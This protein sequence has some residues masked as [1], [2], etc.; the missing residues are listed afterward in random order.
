MRWLTAHTWLL[1]LVP[2]IAGILLCY[3]TNFP[4]DL[5]ADT[6]VDYLDCDT[7]LCLHLMDEGQ[8][9][10]RTIRYTAQAAD[11]SRLLLYL[12]KDSL[13]YPR[14][15]DVLLVQTSVKRGELL[16]EFD[17]GRYLRMQGLVGTAWANRRNWQVVAHQP[18]TGIRATAKR[19]Q[20]ALHERY[21]QLGI[22]PQELGI[23]SALTLGYRDELDRQVQEHF[24]RAG[25]MH[26]LAVS[27]LHTGI[28]WGIILW[29]L[30]L[31][32]AVKPMY[33]H[34]GWR[35]AL[36]II[37]IATLWIYAFVTGLSESVMRSALMLTM[38]EI[39][40]LLR[41]NVS[42]VNS[43]AAA[44][45]I[46]LLIN[47]LALWDV[48][49]Q[50]SFMAM[51]GILLVAQRMQQRIVVRGK[52]GQYVCGLLVMSVSAQI[53]TLPISLHYFG[54]TSNYFALTNLVVVPAAF[55]L[56]LLGI[57][58]LAL[59]CFCVGEYIARLAEYATCGLRK[60]VEWIDSLPY[61]ST[62]IELSAAAVACCYGAII[63]ALMMMRREKVNWWW[64]AGVICC[65]AGVIV[66]H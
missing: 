36:G 8:D 29:I 59:S 27:G 18:I 49:F 45:V 56:L 12:Q 53:A 33:E 41:R 61:A 44:A 10:T 63:C 9:R 47:P 24:S 14:M 28:V 22:A 40:W 5:F 16:G 19:C 13:S 7:V 2:L 35:C 46:I 52:F 32:G 23:L 15:G 3:Y 38:V 21:R 51:L 54:Q 17:Y 66:L 11:G 57:S 64:L 34:W 1:A 31:G 6:A 50:L 43:I 62:H 4:R 65:L 55:V 58:A 60:F 26:I 48:G 25:A 37:A 39:G 42:S 30:T 20:Y